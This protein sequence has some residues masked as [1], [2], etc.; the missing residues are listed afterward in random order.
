[1]WVMGMPKNLFLVRHGQSEG[2]LVRKQYEES[3]NESFF[4]DEFLGLHESQYSLTPLGVQQAEKAGK[5]FK[6]KE[7]VIFDRMLVSNNVRA[8]Q[9]AAHLELPDASWMIDFNLRERDGGLFNVIT[10]SK[11]DSEYSDHKKFYSSQPFLYRPPQGE[12]IADVCQR[13]KIVLDTLA[14]EC[15]GKNVI[16][17]C[18]GHVMRTF[19]IILEKMSL[20]KTN[21]YLK[22]QTEDTAVPNCSIIHYTR[23]NPFDHKQGLSSRFNWVRVI[24]P[25]GGGNFEDDF[26]I[27][28]RKKYTNEELLEEA[29]IN[30]SL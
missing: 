14:R 1:M 15:D 13:I 25:A 2:N 10:P 16:I 8:M 9:T 22:G 5:W 17:V 18:H 28:E 7:F 20:L 29:K 21:E 24:R 11:R 30:R 27:I 23:D 26:S 12:S 6:D 19:R 3:G 4:T